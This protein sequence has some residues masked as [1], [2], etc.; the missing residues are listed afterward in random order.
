MSTSFSCKQK[1]TVSDCILKEQLGKYA[2][3][4]GMGCEGKRRVSDDPF[5]FL[6]VAITRDGEG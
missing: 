2:N 3:G 6:Q 5:L 4:L 1:F